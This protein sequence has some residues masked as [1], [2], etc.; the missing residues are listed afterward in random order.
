MTVAVSGPEDANTLILCA[1]LAKPS[2]SAHEDDRTVT[3]TLLVGPV[4]QRREFVRAA[5]SAAIAKMYFSIDS[6][7]TGTG[8]SAHW[9]ILSVEADW[10]DE[11]SQVEVRVE[12]ELIAGTDTSISLTG[13]AYNVSILAAIPPGEAS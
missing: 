8:V 5:A 10:D 11:S 1:G 7:S 12:V 3:Y 4:L 13:F 6:G 9:N 2:L